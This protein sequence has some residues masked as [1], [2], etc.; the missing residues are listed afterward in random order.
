M[1]PIIDEKRF[2]QQKPLSYFTLGGAILKSRN[3]TN[4]TVI[5]PDL[6]GQVALRIALLLFRKI[7]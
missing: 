2:P 1:K 3:Y 6:A 7:R 4:T 5:L